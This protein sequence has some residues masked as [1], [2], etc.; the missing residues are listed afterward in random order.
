MSCSCS[1][2]SIVDV[3]GAL[4]VVSHAVGTS[5]A[6]S[7]YAEGSDVLTLYLW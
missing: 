1:N 7:A 2:S 3:S 6:Q 4:S 5:G